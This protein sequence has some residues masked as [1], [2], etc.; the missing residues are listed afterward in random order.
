M[1]AGPYPARL[2]AAACC[3]L[4]AAGV[5]LAAEADGAPVAAA[6]SRWA[7]PR[8]ASLNDL[9]IDSLRQ[10]RYGS[11]LRVVR[12]LA[13]T[14][15]EDSPRGDSPAG[16]PRRAV[17]ATYDSD[18]LSVFT[19]ID[20]PSTPMPARGFPAVVFL[21]GWYSNE[22]A[23]NFDFAAGPDSQYARV[24]DAFVAAG[25]VV[26]YPGWRGY[27]T[28]DGHAA[29]GG[30]FLEAWNNASYLMPTFFAIDVL[31]LLDGLPSVAR[32][33]WRD[34]GFASARAVRLDPASIHLAGHSQ[35]GDVALAVLAVAGEGSRLRT[36]LASGS[37][38]AGCF[39]PRF[40]QVEAYG[41]MLSTTEA[42]FSGDGTWTGTA[43]TKDGSV[44]P[45]FVFGWPPDWIGTVDPRSPE[46]TWQAAQWSLPTVAD[47]LRRKYAEMYQA[48]NRN[49]ADLGTAGFEVRVDANGKAYV[50]ND[51]RVAEAMQRI[52]GYAYPQYLQEPLALHFSDRDFY[53]TPAWNEDLNRRVNAAGGHSIAFVYPGNTHGLGKS[54]HAWF[55]GPDV[56]PGFQLMLERDI[57]LFRGRDPVMVGR[58]VTS[59]WPDPPKSRPAAAR[60]AQ[61]HEKSEA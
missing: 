26:F 24:I 30:A 34:W 23:P 35:G 31:N 33:D 9:S 7:E 13:T 50:V 27:G 19:R 40:Q 17:I 46:W 12:Q 32:I 22:D 4:A 21:H 48:L 58:V 25:F 61:R 10:R 5:A 42:F 56:Q 57:A 37:I 28:V 54:E 8:I 43:R 55:S 39:A 1:F 49:V 60:P 18:G 6:Y 59:S 3:L 15:A 14:A 52:G 53:S 29:E 2:V 45:N 20:V 36:S 16:A 38:W 44:N 41:P 51:P 47:A 11:A